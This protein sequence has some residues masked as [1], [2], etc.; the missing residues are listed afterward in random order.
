MAAPVSEARKA[1]RREAMQQR[2]A[3]TRASHSI[4]GS[5]AVVSPDPSMVEWLAL[6]GYSA[7]PATRVVIG[8]GDIER[9]PARTAR[10]PAGRPSPRRQYKGVAA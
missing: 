5:C 7:T 4:G 8:H 9:V 6:R 2:R 1:R 10:P 3:W